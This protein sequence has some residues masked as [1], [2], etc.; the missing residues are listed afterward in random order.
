MCSV[1]HGSSSVLNTATIKPIH[2]KSYGT[3]GLFHI[4]LD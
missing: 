2:S 3:T 4:S 1:I